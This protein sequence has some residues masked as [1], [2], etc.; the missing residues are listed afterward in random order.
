MRLKSFK[1][2]ILGIKKI[3]FREKF[4]LVVAIREGGV[5]P[6]YLLAQCLKK[7]LEFISIKFKNEKNKPLY[8]EPRLVKPVNFIYLDKSILLVDDRAFSGK[9]LELAK[10]VLTGVALI[11]TFVVNGRADYS[12]FDEECFRMPWD[13]GRD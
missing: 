12:L 11:R 2:V 9:T 1:E 10:K 6:A 3:S 8:K 7:P 4:D 13:I 5:V